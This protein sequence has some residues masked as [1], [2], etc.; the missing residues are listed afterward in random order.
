[1]EIKNKENLK[2]MY[3]NY[4]CNLI[5]QS[6]HHKIRVF[7]SA[8]HVDITYYGRKW[9]QRNKTF[10]YLPSIRMRNI[11]LNWLNSFNYTME[12]VEK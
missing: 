2:I 5:N 6:K 1:M 11:L 9:Y 12:C 8:N 7:T 4:L 3:I 10:L